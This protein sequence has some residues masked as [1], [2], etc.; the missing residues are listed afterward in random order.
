MGY[1]VV[2]LLFIAFGL[3]LLL[4]EWS[5]SR[6]YQPISATIIRSEVRNRPGRRQYFP[7]IEFKYE[8]NGIEYRSDRYRLFS[9]SSNQKRKQQRICSKLKAGTTCTAWYDP[10][11]PAIAVLVKSVNWAGPLAIAI[12]LVILG[13]GVVK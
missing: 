6:H 12:G 2:A 9:Y 8:I 4:K 7:S 11:D 5:A 1:F 3:F 13:I 10:E